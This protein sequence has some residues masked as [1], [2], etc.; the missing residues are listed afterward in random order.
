[1]PRPDKPK[2]LGTNAGTLSYWSPEQISKEPVDERADVFAF[3][4]TAYEMITGKKPITGNSQEEILS[5]YVNFNQNLVPINERVDGVPP[6]IE[7]TIRKCL[8]MDINRRY[9]SMSLVVRDLQ[10]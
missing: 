6:A 5:K 8:E 9:P 10:S 7:Q 2:K 4:V 1:M 3:G